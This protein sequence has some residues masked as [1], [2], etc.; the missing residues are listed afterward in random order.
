[1]EIREFPNTWETRNPETGEHQRNNH[2]LE[3]RETT[4]KCTRCKHYFDAATDANKF[5]CG[6]PCEH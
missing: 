6:E 1:M 5:I 3:L 2:N 4:W